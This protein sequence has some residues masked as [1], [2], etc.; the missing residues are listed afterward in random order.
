MKL[1][2]SVP[3]IALIAGAAIGFCLKPSQPAE[4]TAAETSATKTQAA[5][6]IADASGDA[7]VEAMRSRIKEL[8]AMLAAAASQNAEKPEPAAQEGDEPGRHGRRERFNPREMMERLKTED[9]ERYAQMTNRMARFRQHRT[10]MAQS[11]LDFLASIDLSSQGEEAQA[12]HSKLQS[13]IAKREELEE[14]LHSEDISDEE[15]DAAMQQIFSMEREMRHLYREERSNLLSEV[16]QELGFSGDDAADITATLSD[17]IEATSSHFGHGGP[18][19]PGGGGRG[20]G[21]PRR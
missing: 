5:A 6:Q 3:V 11:K 7:G 10:E 20:P 21:G 19:G 15:R 16:V 18:G 17:I 1:N 9:P 13:M 4:T 8:E 2:F 12:T 14:K